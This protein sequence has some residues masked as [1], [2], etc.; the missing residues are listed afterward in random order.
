MRK[1]LYESKQ[2]FENDINKV[3]AW[4]QKLSKFWGVHPSAFNLLPC[5][6]G[7]V[8]GPIHITLKTDL[9][10]REA[11]AT[12]DGSQNRQNDSQS[13]GSFTQ[14]TS[15]DSQS[16]DNS[17][18]MTE[19][20]DVTM[21]ELASSQ[22]ESGSCMSN[23]LNAVQ[24]NTNALTSKEHLFYTSGIIED[25]SIIEKVTFTHPVPWVLVIEKE[26]MFNDCIT[27]FNQALN[28]GRNN[29]GKGFGIIITV[30]RMKDILF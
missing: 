22:Q 1:I 28:S 9:I 4:V 18:Q 12:S 29:N 15:S 21:S 27:K 17:G 2:T 11:N 14:V 19:E 7:Q 3:S 24:R 16:T 23:T 13:T 8:A 20:E 25:I 30:N 5:P 6:K 26:T 10:V